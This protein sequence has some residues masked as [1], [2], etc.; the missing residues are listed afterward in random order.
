MKF[1]TGWNEP[2]AW[3]EAEPVQHD[4]SKEARKSLAYVMREDAN[5]VEDYPPLVQQLRE[6]ADE[7]E[8]GE[9]EYSAVIGRYHYFVK[10]V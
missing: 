2:D 5:D 6:A 9:G 4:D 1:I 3:P 8:N 7:V 10:A